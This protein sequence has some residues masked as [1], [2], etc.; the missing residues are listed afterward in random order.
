ML[1]AFELIKKHGVSAV[2]FLG[3]FWMNSRLEN[4]EN[5]LYSC[6]EAKAAIQRGVGK[7]TLHK[8]PIY[9]AI[10]SNEITL[11][12]TKRHSEA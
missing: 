10:L 9:F 6:W 11:R 8:Q 3:L 12:D 5:K 4:V 7:N 1:D 2:M